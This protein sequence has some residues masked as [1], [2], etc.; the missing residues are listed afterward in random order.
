MISE[1]SEQAR[2]LVAILVSI[3]FLALQL[4]VRP[5]KRAEDEALMLLIELSLII[6][7]TA[8]L[9]VKSCTSSPTVCDTYGLGSDAKG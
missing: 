5:L 2:V 7:Y 8:I 4:S 3:T 1:T 6:I 9:V